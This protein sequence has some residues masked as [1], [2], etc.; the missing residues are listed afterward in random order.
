[1]RE[2]RAIG[3]ENRARPQMYYAIVVRRSYGL[4]SSG[5][6]LEEC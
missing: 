2:L 1:M 3:L 5:V 4:P 6:V